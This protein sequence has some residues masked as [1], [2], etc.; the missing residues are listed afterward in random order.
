MGIR[1]SP[2]NIELPD[3]GLEENHFAYSDQPTSA[4]GP[5]DIPE[6]DDSSQTPEAVVDLPKAARPVPA[7]ETP[8]MGP[9]R[10][11]WQTFFNNKKPVF[12]LKDMKPEHVADPD[13]LRDRNHC[14]VA[15]RRLDHM[16]S[17]EE[18]WQPPHRKYIRGPLKVVAARDASE[19]MQFNVVLN[20]INLENQG[21]C[22]CGTSCRRRCIPSLI[23][24]DRSVPMKTVIT[25]E[26]AHTLISVH[27]AELWVPADPEPEPEPLRPLPP[28][29]SPP[30]ANMHAK[31]EDVGKA[32]EVE[33]L[34]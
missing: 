31:V 33:D 21:A 12:S 25:I 11:T 6:A 14:G 26:G 28:P 2:L 3:M 29:D 27:D 22:N 24:V 8:P 17:D 23:S 32:V 9:D 5:V 16:G 15:K 4:D 20:N 7:P 1:R 34:D 13:R 18:G 19:D 30:Q 10:E